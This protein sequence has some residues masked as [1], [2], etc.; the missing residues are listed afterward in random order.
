MNRYRIQSLLGFA[1]YLIYGCASAAAA[2]TDQDSHLAPAVAK[3]MLQRAAT[4]TLLTYCGQQYPQLHA[5]ADR[6][7]AFWLQHNQ[8]VLDKASRLHQQILRDIKQTQS[9]FAAEMFA[10]DI[11]RSVE[12]TVQEFKSTLAAY[13]VQQQHTVCNRLILSVRNGDWDVRHKQ[14]E[15]FSLLQKYP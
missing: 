12:H 5:A 2:S 3:V 15:A 10:L 7:T 8:A 13:P 1:L 11:D 14:A 4:T 9:Q 6:A